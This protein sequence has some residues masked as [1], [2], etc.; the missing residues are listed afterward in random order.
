MA[1]CRSAWAAVIKY[2]VDQPV[3]RMFPAIAFYSTQ[4]ITCVRIGRST[5]DLKAIQAQWMIVQN[6]VRSGSR[7]QQLDQLSI[8]GAVIRFNGIV[9]FHRSMK[10]PAL[11]S[12]LP[13]ILKAGFYPG[14]PDGSAFINVFRFLLRPS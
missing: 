8:H 3:A 10:A 9:Y 4:Y 1:R 5:S 2:R 11:I 13:K 12:L 7:G 6:G 14:L